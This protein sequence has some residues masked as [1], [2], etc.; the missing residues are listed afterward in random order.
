MFKLGKRAISQFI[1]SECQRR[2]RLDLYPSDKARIA[3]NAP[4]KDA[5]RP[6]FKLLTEQGIEFE[7]KKFFELESV[8]GAHVK[9]G[10]KKPRKADDELAFGARCLLDHWREDLIPGNY[11]IEGQFEIGQHGAF[12]RNNDLED[13]AVDT[14]AAVRPD[15]IQV[16]AAGSEARRIIHVDGRLETL[17]LSDDRI[18]LRIIDVKFSPQSIASALRRAGVLWDDLGW[19]ACRPRSHGPLRRSVERCNLVGK[20]RSIGPVPGGKRGCPTGTNN[21]LR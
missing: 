16:M 4:V 21:V 19:L 8:F 10:E 7:A 11:L 17:D 14:F 3:A 9:H 12:V 20:A 6:G 18:G 13:I 2:L 15:I 5:H 1:R